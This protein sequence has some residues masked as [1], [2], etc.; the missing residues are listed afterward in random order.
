MIETN[1]APYLTSYGSG[2]FKNH[3]HKSINS[4]KLFFEI[5]HFA[6]AIAIAFFI[7]FMIDRDFSAGYNHSGH[8]FFCIT[9][10]LPGLNEIV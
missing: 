4:S 6:T 2:Q 1:Q 9:N 8:C 3:I 7:P 10:N 5:R